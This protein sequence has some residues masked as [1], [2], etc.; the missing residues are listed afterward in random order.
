LSDRLAA[1]EN[2][3]PAYRAIEPVAVI[4]LLCGLT[5]ALCFADLRF[6]VAAGAALV[7]GAW[8]DWKIRRMPEVYTGR[9]L[10]QAG[11]ALGI[12]FSLSSATIS[13]VQAAVLRRDALQFAKQYVTVLKG[14]KIADAVW[15]RLPPDERRAMTP[16]EILKKMNQGDPMS[17][18]SH[19]GPTKSLLKRVKEG[20]DVQVEEIEDSG[21][22]ELTRVA[23][24]LL[25]VSGP[26]DPKHPEQ[27]YGLIQV[28]SDPGGKVP[29]W[30]LGNII[31]P[32]PRKTAKLAAAKAKDDG[33]GHA[34]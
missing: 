31:Y 30:Y 6:L 5:A 16:E 11:I 15:Y 10:A 1:I 33:H 24:V 2:E 12:V 4:S 3:I 34:H 26:V 21:Y 8:A 18:E 9:G 23:N 17:I 14:G 13:Y 22:E 19:I 27:G 25:T 7:L 28:R 29:G 20:S 32:Y